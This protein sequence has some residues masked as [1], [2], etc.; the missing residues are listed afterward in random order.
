MTTQK[1]ACPRWA[2][3]L[4]EAPLL[5]HRFL[6]HLKESGHSDGTITHYRASAYHFALWLER[7]GKRLSEIDL[8]LIERFARHRCKCMSGRRTNRISLLCIGRI[9][10]FVRFLAKEQ[11]VRPIDAPRKPVDDRLVRFSDWLR[12][13]RGL[14]EATIKGRL[15]QLEKL[16]S[17]LGRNPR[18]YTTALIK[19]VALAEARNHQPHVAQNKMTA[20]RSYLRFLAANGECRASLDH[21]VPTIARWR[22]ANLPK[23]VSAADVERIVASCEAVRPASSRDKAILLLL[24]R[25]GLRAGDIF[26]LRLDDI[27]WEEGTIRVSGKGRRGTRLPLPQDVGNALLSYINDGRP[28]TSDTRVFQRAM[29][30]YKPLLRSTVISRVVANAIGR[31]GLTN[32]PSHGANLLRHSA[33]TA[34]LRGGASLDLIGTVLRHKSPDT[35]LIYAKLDAST[36]KRVAQPWP[37]R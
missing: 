31:A 3:E 34:M 2:T 20:L 26:N 22:L 7:C 27:S 14:S 32:A 15:W 37:G 35:T 16:L 19:R 5:I 23:Y 36:L 18:A 9:R 21:A 10:R 13:H 28:C 33:A 6:D 17:A 25:L 1:Q 12:M 29:A 30:P 11:L 4:L 24:A 8:R